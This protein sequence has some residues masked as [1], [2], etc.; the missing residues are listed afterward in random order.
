MGQREIANPPNLFHPKL[1]LFSGVAEPTVAWI[2]SANFTGNGMAIN[3]ELMLETDDETVVTELDGWFCRKW[4]ELPQKTEEEFAAYASQWRAPG[5]YV[6]DRGGVQQLPDGRKEP[7]RR[8]LRIRL[9]P[10]LRQPHQNFQGTMAFGA[11]D[12]RRYGSAAAGLRQLLVWLACARE[13]PFLEA[14]RGNHAFQRRRG[15]TTKYYIAQSPTRETAIADGELYDT[16][17]GVTCL[18]R[19]GGSTW[20]MSG[21]SNNEAKWRMARAAVD[22]ANASFDD[23]LVLEDYESITWPDRQTE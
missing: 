11:G 9:Y 18:L 10:E 20:W 2:G 17:K 5:R 4:A 21:N 1:Y 7:V 6:G 19:A 14:C 16:T 8:G 23:H 13:G 15:G 22:V 12:I 3:A